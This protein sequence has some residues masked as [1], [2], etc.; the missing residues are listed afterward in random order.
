L[1]RSVYSRVRAKTYF[2]T[3]DEGGRDRSVDLR[4]P[5]RPYELLINL[6]LGSTEEGFPIR[7]MARVVL[8]GGSGYI[9]LGVEQTLQIEVQCIEGAIEPGVSFDLSEGPKTVAKGTVVAVL[10]SHP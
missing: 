10:E 1:T 7:C 2:L 4:D 9:E 5:R 3:P 8:E 6:G